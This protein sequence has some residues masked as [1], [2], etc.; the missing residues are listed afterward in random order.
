M[1]ILYL[2]TPTGASGNMLLAALLDAGVPREAWEQQLYSLPLEG[3]RLKI[4][5]T[6]RHGLRACHVQVEVTASQ[7]HRCL[8]D[9]A[10]VIQASAL[11]ETV[12][13]QS[14]AVFH[15]LAAA[16]AR[17]HGTTVADVHFH[18]VGAVDAL[19]D[20]TGTVLA[21]Y[22]LQV[23]EI[24][25]S[26]PPLGS[27]WVQASH[28]YLPVPAPATVELLHGLPVRATELEGEL[29]TPTGAAL[30]A[31]LC[32]RFGPLPSMR[33]LAVGYGA[34]DRELGRPNVLRAF[35]GETPPSPAAAG[36]ET[37]TVCVL[38]ANVDDLNPQVYPH[39][40]ER[41]LAGPA[42]DVFWTPVQMKKGR[43]GILFTV[44][45]SPEK[46]GTCAHLIFRE[47]T[48][49]GLRMR[50]EK[51]YKLPR[52]I[53][54]VQTPWGAVRIKVSPAL[55]AEREPLVAPEFADCQ[56]AALTSGLPLREV[57]ERVTRLARRQLEEVFHQPSQQNGHQ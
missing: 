57:Q 25:A 16:E 51:R 43:P 24:T 18:E 23:T 1:R 40:A 53:Y 39:L 49:L 5:E 45:C 46:A 44:L 10:A 3:Y 47:T 4:T 19:L 29:V 30:L 8:A 26:P 42:L 37:D 32:N 9:V 50:R 35:L 33:L 27:G 7:P 14:L 36:Y 56:Q 38:E 13:Q 48:T 15:R 52:S 12:Q 22:M 34:G 21:A 55:D 11:P 28:G 6:N 20:I 54:S 17:V 41:L 31:T 2:D